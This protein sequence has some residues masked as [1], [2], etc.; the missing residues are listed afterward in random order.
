[1]K[2]LKTLLSLTLTTTFGACGKSKTSKI[3]STVVIDFKGF[4]DGVPF[5]GG[6]AKDYR[7]KLGS[8]IFIPGFEEQLVGYKEG[9]AVEVTVKFPDD[10]LKKSLAGK[11]AVFE[12]K[13]KKVK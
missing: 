13:I 4:V 7:L 1:M 8:K 11:K 6:E 10:Y 5:T 12:V 2:L 9:D 3:G